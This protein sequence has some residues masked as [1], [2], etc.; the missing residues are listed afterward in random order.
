MGFGSPWLNEDSLF[1]L[2]QRA[3]YLHERPLPSQQAPFGEVYRYVTL[4]TRVVTM[5][6]RVPVT[7]HPLFVGGALLTNPGRVK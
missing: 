1:Q 6:F 2:V 5:S 3:W 4:L 7:T